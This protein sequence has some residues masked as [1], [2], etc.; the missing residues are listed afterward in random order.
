MADLSL[1]DM[2]N[3]VSQSAQT[4]K[5]SASENSALL[6]KAFTRQRRRSRE[7]ETAVFG[8]DLSDVDKLRKILDDIDEDSSGSLDVDGTYAFSSSYRL[9]PSF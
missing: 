1:M 3:S 7:L 6:E 9:S 5:D 4:V 2:L 8:K